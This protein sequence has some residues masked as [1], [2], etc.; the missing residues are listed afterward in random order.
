MERI[1]RQIDLHPEKST[2]SHPDAQ[3]TEDICPQLFQRHKAGYDVN[4]DGSIDLIFE[5][6]E[7]D[8][9]GQISVG[10]AYSGE[11]NFVGTFS[12]SIPNFVAL[13]RN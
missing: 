3:Q 5:V 4:S 9:I 1:R 11:S 6:T 10:A 13:A 12:T 8:N 2:N 7:K